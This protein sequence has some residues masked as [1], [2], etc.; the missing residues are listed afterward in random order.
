MLRCFGNS[1]LSPGRVSSGLG[2][3]VPSWQQLVVVRAPVLQAAC[4]RVCLVRVLAKAAQFMFTAHR[5]LL[6]PPNLSGVQSK[7]N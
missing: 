5:Q 2:W 6:R 3:A 1:V 4:G 7:G